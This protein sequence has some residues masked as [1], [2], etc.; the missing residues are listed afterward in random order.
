MGAIA[1]AIGGGAL[2]SAGGGLLGG[3]AANRAGREARDFADRDA[4]GN[5]SRLGGSLY[6][7]QYGYVPTLNRLLGQAQQRNNRGEAERLSGEIQSLMQPTSG[8]ILGR[9]GSLTNEIGARQNA[10]LGRFDSGASWLDQQ[11]RDARNALGS[12]VNRNNGLALGAESLAGSTGIGRERMIRRD[13]ARDLSN[14]DARSQAALSASGFGNSTAVGNAMTNNARVTGEARDNAIQNATDSRLGAQLAAR[15]QRIGVGER[16]ANALYG[17]DVTGA[18]AATA[19]ESQRLGLT[20]A[21]LANEQA[22]RLMPLQTELGIQQGGVF[23]PGNSTAQYYPGASGGANA[24]SSF[25][26]TATAG[27]GLLAALGRLGGGAS[28][29]GAGGGAGGNMMS[30]ISFEELQRLLGG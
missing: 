16:G 10:D 6:G 27:G 25:G 9:M 14:L 26:N 22:L 21:Q 13:A 12:S 17:A 7:A 4:L 30:G 3:V 11:Y 29:G 24:L 20:Q 18:N 8:S 5:Q 19:R 2:L 28:G 23:N 15:S 1:A